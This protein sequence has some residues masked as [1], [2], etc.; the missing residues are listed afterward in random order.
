MLRWFCVAE[1]GET[2]GDRER[3]R[4]REITRLPL[5][6]SSFF[7]SLHFFFLLDLSLSLSFSFS[8]HHTKLFFFFFVLFVPQDRLFLFTKNKNAFLRVDHE[9]PSRFQ[10]INLSRYGSFS[11]ISISFNLND[12]TRFSRCLVLQ[13]LRIRYTEFGYLI[14][15]LH[16]DN[17]RLSNFG[18]ENLQHNQEQLTVFFVIRLRRR[19]KWLDVE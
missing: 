1:S 5:P 10:V 2:E 18:F 14:S 6:F 13:A 4:Q 15:G 19:E 12:V 9:R 3:E 16:I 11:P 7:F 17:H 8:H